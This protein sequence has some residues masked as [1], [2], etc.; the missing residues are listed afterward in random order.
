[1]LHLL[2]FLLSFTVTTKEERERGEEV[3]QRLQKQPE[4]S[5]MLFAVFACSLCMYKKDQ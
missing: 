2:I 4:R 5:H 1:M 3:E